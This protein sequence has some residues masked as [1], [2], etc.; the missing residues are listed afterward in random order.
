MKYRKESNEVLYSLEEVTNLRG[1]DLEELKR[2]AELN[3]RKRIRICTHT[4]PEDH[5]HEMI[6]V[7]SKEAVVPIHKH[8][9]RAESFTIFEGEATV[10]IYSEDGK[11]IDSIEMGEVTSGKAFYYRINKNTYHTL[12]IKSDYLVFHEVTEGP[13]QREMSMNAPWSQE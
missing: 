7:H 3:P 4:T 9:D 12:K 5:M 6:I 2:L 1:E 13:F 10:E 11:K 8:L